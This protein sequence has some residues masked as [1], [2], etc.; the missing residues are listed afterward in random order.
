MTNPTLQQ[1]IAK[2]ED[3]LV[4]DKDL[5]P[6]PVFAY[7]T[8]GRD[9]EQL[10][11]LDINKAFDDYRQRHA[12]NELVQSFKTV[13]D[14]FSYVEQSDEAKSTIISVVF[15]DMRKKRPHENAYKG[16]NTVETVIDISTAKEQQ[17]IYDYID[18][19]SGVEHE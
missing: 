14:L 12:D 3:S 8:M 18:K 15:D 6:L 17:S 13:D 5:P 9:S 1:R 19:E 4:K 11:Q 16:L 2:L 10:K 7:Y